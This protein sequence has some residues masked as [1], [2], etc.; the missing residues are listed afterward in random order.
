[1][2]IS[3]FSYAYSRHG[4]I[5][6]LNVLIGKIGFKYRF[7][8]PIDKII[9]YHCCKIEKFANNKI[10]GGFYKNTYL[11]INKNWSSYDAS[12]K[13]LGLYELEVQKEIFDIQKNKILNKKYFINL[14]AG[15][16]FHLV[17]TIYKKIFNK[18][19]AF[20]IDE[21]AKKILHKNLI[22]NKLN[23]KVEIF[24]KAENDFLENLE[25]KKIKLKECLFLFDIE[26]DEFKILNNKNLNKLNKSIL[27]I[28]IH[29]FYFPPKKFINKLSKKFKLKILTTGNRNLSDFEFLANMHDTEKW[30]LV[31][32]GRPKKM[33]WIVCMP[34]KN[35]N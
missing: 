27:I 26:G 3:K 32:E 31:N 1:M 24:D 20:E 15:E 22:K 28:E 29:D 30:L 23:K 33:Q 11:E 10:L 34:K 4:L 18:G 5:G 9:N 2:N 14:G 7:K 16:G 25:T 6:F 35:E 12:S 8:T 21:N 19:I 17:G 13:F